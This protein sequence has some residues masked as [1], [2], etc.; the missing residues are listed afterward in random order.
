MDARVG[1][2]ITAA[3]SV[4]SHHILEKTKHGEKR[5]DTQGDEVVNSIAVCLHLSTH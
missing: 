4:I 2:D 1:A 3:V 5:R